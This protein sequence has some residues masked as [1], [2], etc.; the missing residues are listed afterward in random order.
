MKRIWYLPLVVFLILSSSP[1]FGKNTR[2][3]ALITYVRLTPNAYESISPAQV[4]SAIDYGGFIWAEV[5][6]AQMESMRQK[7]IPFEPQPNA[8]QIRLQDYVID[9]RTGEPPIPADLRQSL[10]PGEP[11]FQLVQFAGPPRNEWLAGVEKT[12]LRMLQYVPQNAY[13][14]W[15]VQERLNIVQ[16]AAPVRWTGAFHPAYKI[17][18]ALSGKTGLIEN[19]NVLIYDDGG[20]SAT[21][22]AIKGMGARYIQDF[23]VPVLRHGRLVNAVFAIEKSLLK[24]VAR[25]PRVLQ[26]D[27]CSPVPGFDDEV[28]DQIVVGNHSGGVPFTGYQSW[29]TAHGVDG[30]GVIFADVD[31]GCD[32]NN[33]A[34]A[35]EDIRGRIA[36]FVSYTGSPAT[37]TNGHGTHTSG[38]IAGNATLGDI[39]AN[40][41]LFGLG[42]AP[43]AQL[44][45][46]NALMGYS[47]PPSGGWQKLSKDS[48]LNGA[49][50]S[51]NSWYTGAPGAQGYTSACVTHD[52]MVRDADFDTPSVAEP[53]VM[54][55]SAGNW[56]SG[57]S[58]ISEPKE[59]KNLIVVGASENYRTD[60]PLGPGCGASSNID[61]VVDFSSRGPC[62]DGRR[63][64]TLVAPGSDVASLRS[65]TGYYSGCG[66]VVSGHTDYVY[67]SGTSMAC[68]VVSGGVT[69]I[70]QWWKGFNSGSAPSPA[71]AKALL[72]NGATDMGTPDVPNNSEGWGRMNLDNVIDNGEAMFYLD[73]THTFTESGEIWQDSGNVFDPA[74]PLKVTLA[75]TDAPGIAG[76]NA[77][78]NDL[79]LEVDVGG[80]TYKGNVF[81]G[82]WST[83]GGTADY[84]NN[85][86]CVYVQSPGAASVNVRVIAATIAGDGVPYN[87]DG[88]DQD[89]ALVAYNYV[90]ST[91]TPTP[92]ITPTPTETPTEA[93]TD[94]PTITP[95]ETPPPPITP[96]STHTPSSPLVVLPSTLTAGESFSVY[97]AL[98]EDITQPF[99]F[100]L[101][102]D[103]PAGPYT[104]CLDGNIKKGI[105]PLYENVPRFSAPY[106]TMVRPAVNI[107]ESMKGQTITFY[108]AII[109]AGK[110]PPV[111]KLSDLTPT[112]PYIIFMDKGAAVVN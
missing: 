61:N 44:V 22:E 69:L 111:A 53:L 48:V 32:T 88:T 64:P 94:I 76:G 87:G 30:S 36:A 60:N 52:L 79:D 80:T 106:S 10:S 29:L 49:V 62:L 109:Q 35:H 108:A 31:T 5:S 92:T 110:V 20:A 50:G 6:D 112:T 72:V 75:W 1:L 105:I 51:S 70:T 101:L 12:G 38:I 82:G 74:K 95:T 13:L 17:A 99:D 11:G 26:I 93:P 91:P 67:M 100:Y 27:Y 103:T 15:G 81:S 47:W 89:F 25:L 71:M 21:L 96:T 42:M 2:R 19:V 104:I 55:F 84:Q 98:T 3:N 33:N 66:Q 57:A 46:Q 28:S 56:G 16:S 78:V 83:T 102:A 39:D 77:W 23:P 73:Q 37:D 107:P 59:A 85:I 4:S 90:L 58:T 14:V 8:T 86:E 43:S 9:T 45:V 40:G 54:V 65:Y 7:G 68:P 63:A 34:T 18:S 97:L 41:F 24:D